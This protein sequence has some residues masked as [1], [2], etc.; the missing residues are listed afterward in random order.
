VW[1]FPDTLGK[2]LEEVAVLFGDTD[3]VAV[4][5]TDFD[6]GKSIEVNMNE[7]TGKKEK[8]EE[9]IEDVTVSPA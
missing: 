8:T 4:Y 2:P 9:M 6:N 1:F 7:G 5:Q 3:M